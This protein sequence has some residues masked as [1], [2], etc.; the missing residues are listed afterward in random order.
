M[1]KE[2]KKLSGRV[3]NVEG[4][5]GMEGLNY[6]DLCIQQDVELP[7]GYKPPKFEMFDG[8][9]DPKNP[10]KCPNKVSMASDFIDRFRFN[11]ENTPD[12]FYIQNPK[13]QPTETFREYATRWRSEAVKVRPPLAEE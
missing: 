10:K 12:V 4:G 5:K 9:D 1:A 8:T 2:L 3:Q 11:T 13:K 6:E 7:E